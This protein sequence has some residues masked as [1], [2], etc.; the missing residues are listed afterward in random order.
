MVD[1]LENTKTCPRCHRFI[2]AE[3]QNSHNCEIPTRGAKTIWFDWVSDGFTDRNDDYYRNAKGLDGTL[4]GLI[5]CKHNPPHSL[6]KRW[7]VDRRDLAV[8]ITIA[9]TLS[10]I[11]S[12]SFVLAHAAS[13]PTEISQTHAPTIEVTLPEVRWIK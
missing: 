5:V 4:Y 6:E 13:S 12:H 8:A 2:I 9:I 7:L 1:D 11:L 10:L 3:Q